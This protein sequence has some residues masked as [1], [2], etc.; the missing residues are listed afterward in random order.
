M[1]YLTAASNQNISLTLLLFMIISEAKFELV[2]RFRSAMN[3]FQLFGAR[4]SMWTREGNYNETN[5]FYVSVD[6]V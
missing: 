5:E 1:T 3:E 4:T 2:S 6:R